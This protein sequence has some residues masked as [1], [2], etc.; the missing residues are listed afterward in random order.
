[1]NDWSHFIVRYFLRDREASEAIQ[2]LL[3]RGVPLCMLADAIEQ[4][5]RQTIAIFPHN[6]VN[7]TE[8]GNYLLMEHYGAR[9]VG[10][11]VAE[12]SDQFDQSE[13]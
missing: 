12:W 11:S 7:Y 3:D 2:P 1:M 4:Y 8:V 13:Y 10:E 6:A 9:E 5:A